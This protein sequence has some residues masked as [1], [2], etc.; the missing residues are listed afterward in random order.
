MPQMELG[1]F[2][3]TGSESRMRMRA[4][5]VGYPSVCAVN[6]LVLFLYILGFSV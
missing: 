6:R 1:H 5:S 2:R 3:F 4:D